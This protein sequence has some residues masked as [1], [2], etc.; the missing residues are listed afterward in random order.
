M[1]RRTWWATTAAS[2]TAGLLA[3]AGSCLHAATTPAPRTLAS[4]EIEERLYQGRY[5]EAE[6]RAGQELARLTGN[7]A[8]ISPEAA[9][10]A[11]LLVQSL[12]DGRRG[13]RPDALV[14][15]RR[16]VQL[17]E[18]NFGASSPEM[19]RSLARL[20]RVL[21]V[22]G[23]HSAAT[24][25]LQRSLH[26]LESMREPDPADLATVQLA[27]GYLS[28][29]TYQSDDAVR[30]A[31]QARDI[32]TGRLGASDLAVAEALELLGVSLAEAGQADEGASH[33]EQAVQIYRHALGSAHPRVG[34]A[35]VLLG[36]TLSYTDSQREEARA[37]LDEGLT[38]LETAYGSESIMTTGALN[39]FGYSYLASANWSKAVWHFERSL[40]IVRREL[41]EDCLQ[42]AEDTLALGIVR[43][44][45]GDFA[46]AA[47]LEARAVAI[48]ERTFDP[49][50]PQ[51]GRALRHLGVSLT[52]LGR[53]S[54]AEPLL[55][56]SLAIVDRNSGG[57]GY[58]VGNALRSLG[59]HYYDA[60][61][62]PAAR[63]YSLRALEVY[64][65]LEADDVP[66]TP[67]AYVLGDL[68]RSSLGL[69]EP[70]MALEY[71]QRGFEIHQRV[72]G[73]AHPDNA[74]YLADIARVHFAMQHYDA[75]RDTLQKADAILRE[76]LRLSARVSPEEQALAAAAGLRYPVDQLLSAAA[77]IPQRNEF[78]AAA[79][80]SAIRARGQVLDGLIE[81]RQLLLKAQDR[82]LA[83]LVRELQTATDRLAKLTVRG[84]GTG[85]NAVFRQELDSARIGLRQAELSLAAR[86]ETLRDTMVSTQSGLQQVSESLPPG[87]ALVAFVRYDYV[88]LATRP[89]EPP[90]PVGKSSPEYMAFVLPAA[91]AMPQAFRLGDA[92]VV[93]AMVARWRAAIASEAQSAGRASSAGESSYRRVAEQL[94][95]SVWDRLVPAIGD[96]AEV[97]IVPDGTLNL[98]SFAALPAADGGY[99]ADTRRR[100]HYLSAERD[101]IMK[102]P[103]RSGGGLLVFGAPAFDHLPSVSRRATRRAAAAGGVTERM[104]RA[105]R[106]APFSC[107][108][109]AAMRFEP[110]PGSTL[111][112][113]QIVQ[114]WDR[115]STQGGRESGP[116]A[117]SLSGSAA[118]EADFKSMASGHRVVHIATHGFFLGDECGSGEAGT[119]GS[120]QPSFDQITRENPLLLS[121]LALA[122]ANRRDD[123]AYEENDGILT[124]QEIA[125]LDLRG[126]E[127][128]VLS[129]CDTGLGSLRAGE[130][131]FGL[132]RAFEL[133][134]AR[135]L[136]LSLWAVDDDATRQW[137][138]ALYRHRFIGGESTIEAVNAAG[139]EIL[140]R[141][142]SRGEST[143]P[144]YWAGYIAAGDWR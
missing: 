38:I 19:V 33:L 125:V 124:A 22:R 129:A 83:N 93:D 86:T 69:G 3:L 29:A 16:A 71:M 122:G 13:A 28:R 109:F 143:H 105:A 68:G 126:T 111:E 62:Y 133:A 78:V 136:V 121:G 26:L 12:L 37:R 70:R 39:A 1:S 54:E 8:E 95:R 47:E 75:A 10:I 94:R 18:R 120:R 116:G 21:T 117:V 73:P 4:S 79:W 104:S 64:Q 112:I 123:A 27:L 91:R 108:T 58:P 74:V 15:A 92:T 55:L 25:S 131:V 36:M 40:A 41:G 52:N 130:G 103:A 115:A 100:L 99:L 60:G 139:A 24:A 101:V 67:V 85:G 128:A 20:G 46:A 5:A 119:Q 42:A 82:D 59:D 114:H 77:A 35:L 61:N 57:H 7:G 30:W 2:V 49:W 63:S 138:G 9:H 6:Q 107:G 81:R 87:S 84:P 31:V 118:S 44:D 135:T 88:E 50:Q 96:A 98:V 51:L 72:L 102:A 132:K 106:G 141:R 32:R 113:Q 53:F 45:M 134:G 89:G 17:N 97:F 14:W 127:W 34:P 90:P 76:H 137:M 11:N 140:R 144:F 110:L 66:S 43:N 80:D 48:L 142:R 23:D 56:R 65:A